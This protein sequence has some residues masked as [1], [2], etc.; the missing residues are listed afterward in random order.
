MHITEILA[1]KASSEVV[2][3]H[4]DSG[5]RDLLALLAQY[6]IGAAVVS[7]DRSTVEGIVS[8]RDVVR[9]LDTD[10]E[11]ILDQP[12]GTIMTRV[13][14]TCTGADTVDALMAVMTE[15]RV[16]HVPVVEEGEL[17][18]VISI[19]DLVKHRIDELTFERDQLEGYLHQV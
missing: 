13:V 4:P 17:K 8:E 10:G 6:N 16:R 2:T 12:V 11:R 3:V 9:R 15:K 18:G 7:S 14:A 1:R 19:G 5:V